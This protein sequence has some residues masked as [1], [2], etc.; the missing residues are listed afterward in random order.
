MSKTLIMNFLNQGGKKVAV[1]VGNVKDGI[2]EAEVKAAM[3]VIV[4]KNIFK[5]TGG[6]LK[7]KDS[8]ELVDKSST[9]FAVK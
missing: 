6:D 2:T 5:S 8:A 3:D 7:S 4:G 9:E 1:R